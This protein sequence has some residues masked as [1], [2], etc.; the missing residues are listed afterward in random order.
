MAPREVRP[1]FREGDIKGITITTEDVTTR[2][3][4][5]QSL[6]DNEAKLRHVLKETKTAIWE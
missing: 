2:V 5:V 4:A 1:W 6:M 3:R